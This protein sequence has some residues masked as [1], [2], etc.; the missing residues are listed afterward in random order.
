MQPAWLGIGAQRSG[1]TWFTELLCRHP[2]V[3]LGVN[4]RKEQQALPKIAAGRMDPAWYLELFQSR[5]AGEFTPRYLRCLSS[6]KIA[7]GLCREDA[8]I[9][10]L[11]RDP[12]ER[13]ISAMRRYE[14]RK[15]RAA[16]PYRA[17]FIEAQWA[18][19]YADQLDVWAESISR[20]RLVIM[21]YE[22]LREDPQPAVDTVWRRLGI[23]PVPLEK[24]DSPSLSSSKAAWQPPDGMIDALVSLYRRQVDRLARN[25]NIDPTKWPNFRE[26]FA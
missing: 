8:P 14:G 16:L 3:E 5:L 20:D 22:V 6:P 9:I 24:I 21:Q 19:M 1:T 15:T 25:W 4:G 13:F 18:G 17:V 7:A 23:D 26:W 11:L 2:K 12:V 10:V